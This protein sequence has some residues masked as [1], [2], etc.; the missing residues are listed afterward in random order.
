MAKTAKE[1]VLGETVT[2][3][4][5]GQQEMP[6]WAAG[7]PPV[8][9]ME[10][11]VAPAEN[12]W[13]R[14]LD[15]RE[16][17]EWVVTQIRAA[18]NDSADIGRSIFAQIAALDSL[19]EVLGGSVETIKGRETLDTILECYSIKFMM[20]DQKDGCPYFSILDVRDSKT[21]ERQ[22]MSVGGW[23]VLAQLARMHYQSAD[24]TPDSPYLVDPET[25]G[26]LAKE[27]FPHYFKIKQKET[28]NGKMNYLAPAMS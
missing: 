19:D 4:L 10:K 15:E 17:M 7:E 11:Y 9:E 23:M 1:S 12:Q 13:R 3:Q 6:P 25:P 20:G 14:K 26:A 27:S 18:G 16:L 24:L 21:N 2:E 22:T 8:G 5:E 28:P